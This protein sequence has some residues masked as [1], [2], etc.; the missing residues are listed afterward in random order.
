[1]EPRA[2]INENGSLSAVRGGRRSVSAEMMQELINTPVRGVFVPNND[3]RE[4]VL[5]ESTDTEIS[6]TYN[7]P[8]GY[9]HGGDVSTPTGLLKVDYDPQTTTTPM[10]PYLMAKGSKLMQMSAP[11][12]PNGKGLFDNEEHELKDKMKLKL[13]QARRRT[14]AFKP[15]VGSPLKKE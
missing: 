13:D 2:L 5:A 14:M 9:Q 12:K 3:E 11:S 15:V 4:T 7:S 10:T 6:S 1:M 8:A